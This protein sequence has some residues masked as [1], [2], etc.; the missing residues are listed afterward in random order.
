MPNRKSVAIQ[1]FFRKI[2]RQLESS[3]FLAKTILSERNF[4]YLAAVAVAISCALAV[5]ILKYFAHNVFIFANYA[6][7]Y[8]KLPFAIIF[9][10]YW[11]FAY[12]F[13]CQ[14]IP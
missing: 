8:L 7:N 13:C 6:N 10:N 2:T 3:F 14:K 4:I 5:I 9:S 12:C 1:L 11:Y